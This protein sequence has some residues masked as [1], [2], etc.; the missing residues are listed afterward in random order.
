MELFRLLNTETPRNSPRKET[1]RNAPKKVEAP[2]V[3]WA[4]RILAE[5]KMAHSATRRRLV[6]ETV[7]WVDQRI[8]A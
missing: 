4:K 6:M 1:P 2:E 3:K 5:E 7:Y 8:K